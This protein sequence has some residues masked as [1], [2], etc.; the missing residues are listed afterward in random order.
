MALYNKEKFVV[1]AIESVLNQ[2]YKDIELVVVDDKSTDGSLEIARRY[3][4]D[5]RVRVI[6]NSENRGVSYT[7][8]KGIRQSKGRVLAFIGADDVYRPEK[9]ELQMREM[10][11]EGGYKDE[12]VYTDYSKMD[13]GGRVIAPK[14][15]E[16]SEINTPV[17]V[18]TLIKEVVDPMFGTIAYLKETALE[19]GLFD[20]SLR[21]RE[22][23][24]LMLR[25]AR[26]R[27][28]VGIFKP[29][30]GYRMVKTSLMHSTPIRESYRVK[31]GIIE[32][33]LQLNPELMKGDDRVEIRRQIAKCLIVIRDYRSALAYSLRYPGMVGDFYY[34]YTRR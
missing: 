30:Y 11:T 1:E 29:L 34:W 22:D 23:Y 25:L 27:P 2:S 17:T 31:L 15:L 6:T 9:I 20:E 28:F 10:S 13:E 26:T 7:W 3:E 19:V 16:G 33:N 4:T 24:E 14:K 5:G 12:I 8:N 18:G 32:K 21:L